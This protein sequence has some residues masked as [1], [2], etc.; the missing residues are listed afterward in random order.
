MAHVRPQRI[1]P[2]LLERVHRDPSQLVV[3]GD[4]LA[5]LVRRPATRALAEVLDGYEALCAVP[6]SLDGEAEGALIV[7]R[8]NRRRRLT[9]EETHAL[10]SLGRTLSAWVAMASARSRAERRATDAET[11]LD[12]AEE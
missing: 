8:G 1:S 6:L 2:A 10:E 7:P 3:L 12:R 9:L 11:A 4:L 5:Q